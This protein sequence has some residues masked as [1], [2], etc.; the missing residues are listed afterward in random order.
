MIS[1]I[2][3]F[4]LIIIMI[5]PPVKIII[6]IFIIQSAIK[7]TMSYSSKFAGLDSMQY[8]DPLH[9]VNQLCKLNVAIIILILH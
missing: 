2:F 9:Y 4:N 8:V 5:D 3:P 7:A 6:N 1:L